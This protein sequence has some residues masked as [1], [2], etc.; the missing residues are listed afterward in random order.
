MADAVAPADGPQAPAGDGGPPAVFFKRRAAGRSNLRKRPAEDGEEEGGDSEMG[1]GAAQVVR[2]AVK[3]K[4]QVAVGATT[5]REGERVFTGAAEAD[6]QRQERGDGGA[7]STVQTETPFDRD[8]RAAREAVLAQAGKLGADGREVDDGLYHGQAGYID[9]RKG[10]RREHTV[11]SEKS[12]GMHG[13]LRAPTNVRFT[14]IMDYKPDICKDYKETG[15]CGFGDSCKFMHD[16]G[17]YKAGWQLDREWEE[18]E[19]QRKEREKAALAGMLGEE[20]GDGLAAAAP[21]E[22]DLPFACLICRRPWGDVRDPVVTKCKHYFC[23]QCA[24]QQHAKSKLCAACN[25]RGVH[26]LPAGPILCDD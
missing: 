23:E 7:T 17:D 20:G 14:F 6:R 8:A 24:L 3:A 22:D 25:V 1:A 2:P 5:A 10:F 18:K 15:Y 4:T 13:P 19:R 11:G 21:P 26:S 16:R 9:Y 12:G